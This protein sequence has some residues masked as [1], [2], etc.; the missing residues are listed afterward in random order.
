MMHQMQGFE[1][2][3]EHQQRIQRAVEQYNQ[4]KRVKQQNQRFSRFVMRFKTVRGTVAEGQP[5]AVSSRITSE[6]RAVEAGS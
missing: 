4:V 2:V 5:R 6:L 3:K 1:M